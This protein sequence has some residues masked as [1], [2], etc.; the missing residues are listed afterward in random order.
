MRRFFALAC[1]VAV[2]AG[3][4]SD[5]GHS[6]SESTVGVA[7]KSATSTQPSSTTMQTLFVSRTTVP[8][9]PTTTTVVYPPEPVDGGWFG[10]EFTAGTDIGWVD[11]ETGIGRLDT[12][13]EAPDALDHVGYRT[14]RLF[15]GG[16]P[17]DLWVWHAGG[18]SRVTALVVGREPNPYAPSEYEVEIEGASRIEPDAAA[19]HALAVWAIDRTASGRWVVTDVMPMVRSGANM[20]YGA[21]V[22]TSRQY[23]LCD[24]DESI[25]VDV[26]AYFDHDDPVVEQFYP[27][28]DAFGV[29]E[30]GQLVVIDG[31]HVRCILAPDWETRGY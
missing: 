1:A 2:L 4:C 24:V 5:P 26:Y 6:T 30:G 23:D 21:L 28:S 10:I 8:P 31:L 9:A 12:W 13:T 27:A 15:V 11:E 14:V 22:D 17:G 19:T 7:I 16:E 18:G 20:S 3:G 25:G 29:G